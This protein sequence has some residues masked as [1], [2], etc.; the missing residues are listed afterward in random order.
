MGTHPI[1]E[2]D[3]DC[4]TE[5]K[6][7]KKMTFFKNMQTS[8][9]YTAFFLLVNKLLKNMNFGK[10]SKHRQRKYVNIATSLVHSAI[11]GTG[12]ILA[13]Y[14][15]PNLQ[16]DLI[17]EES[18]FG[19]HLAQISF[20]YFIYDA[21]DFARINNFRLSAFVEMALH[22]AVCLACF[23]C[24]VSMEKFIGLTMMALLME[25]NSIFL[26]SRTLLLYSGYKN[27][28]FYTIVSIMNLTTLAVFRLYVSF[29]LVR[30][31]MILDDPV[32]GNLLYI[33]ILGN[34][35]VGIMN[36]V[37]F[38]RCFNSDYLQLNKKVKN[39]DFETMNTKEQEVM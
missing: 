16:K 20:G 21:F 28:L 12:A 2:S 35:V 19:F 3:F 22:H 18:T 17:H 10:M 33:G 23:A 15:K 27:T 25:F 1:F 32:V 38:W 9:Q 7:T 14:Q 29:D 31:F 5:Q 30:W 24:T 37:L 26:H 34:T 13:F 8:L 36:L 39:S 6:R 11:T 4:L